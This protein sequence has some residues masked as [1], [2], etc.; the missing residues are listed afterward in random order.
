MYFLFRIKI[1][2][3]NPCAGSSFE[4]VHTKDQNNTP[5]LIRIYGFRI[6]VCFVKKAVKPTKCAKMLLLFF[7]MQC[8]KSHHYPRWDILDCIH[9]YFSMF[10]LPVPLER[11]KPQKKYFLML[12]FKTLPSKIRIQ[13]RK[14][15]NIDNQV[16]S[17][18]KGYCFGSLWNCDHYFNWYY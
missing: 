4:V 5:S 6:Y 9:I 3:G 7:L 17:F 2:I 8:S 1:L 11:F 13:R 10:P 18:W 12:F 15:V 14:K 16:S